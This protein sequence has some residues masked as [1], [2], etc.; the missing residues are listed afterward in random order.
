MRA[1]A[2]STDDLPTLV[3]IEWQHSYTGQ[4]AWITAHGMKLGELHH[5]GGG[6]YDLECSRGRMKIMAS[7]E[8]GDVEPIITSWLKQVALCEGMKAEAA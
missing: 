8:I 5:V 6:R 1:L 2:P 3:R 4:W 7:C